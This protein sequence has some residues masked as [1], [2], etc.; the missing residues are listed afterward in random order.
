[1]TSRFLSEA[2]TAHPHP[3]WDDRTESWDEQTERGAVQEA[4][5]RL[6]AEP[7]LRLLRNPDARVAERPAVSGAEIVLEP[8]LISNERPDGVRYAFDVDLLGLL[9]LAPGCASVPTLAERYNQQFAPVALPNL[10][11]GLAT[12]IAQKWLVWCDTN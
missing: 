11:G 10:L 5:E 1:M 4:F 12:A 2:A 3:F 9:E 7:E 8:R 6:R